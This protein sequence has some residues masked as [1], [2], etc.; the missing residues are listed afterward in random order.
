[1]TTWTTA[2]RDLRCGLCGRVIKTNEALAV[3]RLP[4]VRRE[5]WRCASCA[6]AEQAADRPAG[7]RQ[8]GEEG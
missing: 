1:M 4:E 3:K 6:T 8:A 7:E 2:K 5:L